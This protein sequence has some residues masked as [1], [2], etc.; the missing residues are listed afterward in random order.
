MRSEYGHGIHAYIFDGLG[1]DA[2]REERQD[3]QI[4]VNRAA[5]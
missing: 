3:I 1:E 4:L 5:E 2:V